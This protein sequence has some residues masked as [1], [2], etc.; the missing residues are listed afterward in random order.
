MPSTAG[1]AAVDP[2]VAVDSKGVFHVSWLE[3]PAAGQRR[4][5]AA[6]YVPTGVVFSIPV[7]ISD[8]AASGT[9]DKPSL[10]ALDDGS[11]LA[12]FAITKGQISERFR[13]QYYQECGVDNPPARPLA[14]TY[15]IWALY[16]FLNIPATLK[17][18]HLK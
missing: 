10:A 1:V 8:G 18:C 5:M 13:R 15:G 17:G 2:S 14:F 11:L 9:W 16:S 3:L 12:A 4:V 7:E 6:E